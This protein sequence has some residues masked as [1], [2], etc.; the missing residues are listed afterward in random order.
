MANVYVGYS[1]RAYNAGPSYRCRLLC[2]ARLQSP[3]KAKGIY[4]CFRC[5]TEF[6]GFAHSSNILRRSSSANLCIDFPL[7]IYRIHPVPIQMYSKALTMATLK[8]S[9]ARD[10]EGNFNNA[11][12]TGWGPS[13]ISAR[14]IVTLSYETSI[15]FLNAYQILSKQSFYTCLVVLNIDIHDSTMVTDIF[16][17]FCSK[18]QQ[19]L[20]LLTN[21]IGILVFF[22]RLARAS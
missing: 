3:A 18:F 5:C 17:S 2:C 13:P 21:F 1:E 10:R 14:R 9:N 20:P 8:I 7:E 19:H 4:P 16:F 6:E 12:C 11:S 22:I 15:F